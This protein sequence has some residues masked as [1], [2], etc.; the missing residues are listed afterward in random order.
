[1]AC[2][3][4][5]AYLIQGKGLPYQIMPAMVFACL[6]LAPS[7]AAG[8]AEPEVGPPARPFF[9]DK[10]LIPMLVAPF[11]IGWP[12]LWTHATGSFRSVF[13]SRPLL[14]YVKE[15]YAGRPM[16]IATT[17]FTIPF[18]MM[19]YAGAE[20]ASRFPALWMLPTLV[21]NGGQNNPTVTRVIAALAEDLSRNAPFVVFID[22]TSIIHGMGGTVLLSNIFAGDPRFM[23]ALAAYR[24]ADETPRFNIYELRHNPG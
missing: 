9:R 7:L 18:P 22:R 6:A 1:M 4:L 21:A 13:E 14:K 8:G 15:N 11:L 20:W 23:K 17:D 5:A 12:A 3:F 2:G 16:V 24:K 19:T 10:V